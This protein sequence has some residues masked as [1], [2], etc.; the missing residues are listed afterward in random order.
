MI[1]SI[2]IKNVASYGETGGEIQNLKKMNFFF[3]ANGTGKSTIARYLYNVSLTEGEEDHRFAESTQNGFDSTKETIKVFDADYVSSNF[4]NND[5]LDG[6]FSL[7][8]KNDVIDKEIINK[9]ADIKRIDSDE[10]SNDE[11]KKK[12]DALNNSRKTEMEKLWVF[13]Y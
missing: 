6:V 8:E 2:H 9:E 5:S 12:L 10:K 7:N 4:Y 13:F 3:G 1:D 11:K